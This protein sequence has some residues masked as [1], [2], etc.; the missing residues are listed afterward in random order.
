[1]S[2]AYH[3][4]KINTT[5]LYCNIRKISCLPSSFMTHYSVKRLFKD[6]AEKNSTQPFI[7]S[8][9]ILLLSPYSLGNNISK[10]EIT[11]HYQIIKPYSKKY[12]QHLKLRLWPVVFLLSQLSNLISYIL[13]ICNFDFRGIFTIF[14]QVWVLCFLFPNIVIM[15]HN[16]SE[17]NDIKSTRFNDNCQRLVLLTSSFQ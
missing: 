4:E 17:K 6:Q 11:G 10:A 3:N 12:I 1:L 2:V 7:R 8:S 14:Y 5:V 9:V 13:K 16:I 15:S